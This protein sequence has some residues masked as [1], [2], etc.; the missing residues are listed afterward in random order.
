MVVPIIALAGT[1]LAGALGGSLANS[2]LSK[3]G[4]TDSHNTTSTVTDARSLVVQYPDYQVQ[5]DSPL[6]SQTTKKEASSTSSATPTVTGGNSG[7]DLSSL[8]P[9]ALILGGALIVKEVIK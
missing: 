1:A 8:I 7:I 2:A 6:A 9:V 3:K 5:I 4:S